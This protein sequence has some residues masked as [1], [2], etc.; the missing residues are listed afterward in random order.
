MNERNVA[1]A[2]GTRKRCGGLTRIRLQPGDQLP[3]IVGWKS[4]SCDDPKAGEGKQGHRFEVL[5][6]VVWDR[7]HRRRGDVAAPLPDPDG[8]TVGCGAHDPAGSNRATPT[9]VVFDNDGLAQRR[10]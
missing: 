8:V 9:S 1:S 7:K 5:Q 2:A 10:S 6:N 3:E 4:C